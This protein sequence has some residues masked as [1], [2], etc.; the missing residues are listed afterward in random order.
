[1]TIHAFARLYR[2]FVVDGPGR[3]LIANSGWL[4]FDQF[5]RI[6]AGA[7][8]SLWVA[9]HYGPAQLGALNYAMA[10]VAL[11][12]PIA[13]ASLDVLVIRDLVKDKP[14]ARVI[15]A[16][17]LVMRM[18]A[19]LVS[20][21]GA[22]VMALTARPEDHALLVLVLLSALATI[23][24]SAF[25]ID[26]WYQS[27][28]QTRIGAMVRT[29][30]FTI[31]ALVRI[32]AIIADADVVV[33]AVAVAVE[34]FVAA[35]LFYVFYRNKEGRFLDIGAVDWIRIR[36]Y[37]SEGK[38]LILT[39]V[40]IGVYMRVDRVMIGSLLDNRSVGL[41]SVAVQLCELMY[42][43][44]SAVLLSIYP[45]LVSIHAINEDHYRKRLLQVM[46]AFFYGSLTIAVVFSIS[47]PLII[48]TLLG[49]AYIESASIVRIYIF[50]L[51]IT[52]MSIIFS[53]WYVFYAKT[54]ISM[55]GTV[56][57]G[58]SA[59]L[60]NYLLIPRLGLHGA[61]YAALISTLIP[62]VVVSL[63]FDRRVGK[64]FLDAIMLRFE[65]RNA[66]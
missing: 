40:L 33:L 66:P 4:L 20:V 42:I 25:V 60:L 52:S 57:G 64:I 23:F 37:L 53:H 54:R 19:A 11:W 41:Y 14:S 61:A 32:T 12:A 16:S 29:L 27:Q 44:P 51:P 39:G 21:C 30:S 22:L 55:Y 7:L 10:I 43:L 36:A 63:L 34:A 6:V 31:G 46:A 48:E 50:L 35:M 58:A 28:S 17:A 59:L 65:S 24:Q 49:S 13:L 9:R 8:L 56:A 2:L 47:S 15:L 5:L 38:S 1:M 26:G 62:T 45:T 3:R 18:L